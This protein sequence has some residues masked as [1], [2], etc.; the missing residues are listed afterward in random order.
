MYH[1][2]SIGVSNFVELTQE[3]ILAEQRALLGLNDSDDES[4]Y[5]EE[6]EQDKRLP[7]AKPS[8]VNE[9]QHPIATISHDSHGISLKNVNGKPNSPNSVFQ[10]DAINDHQQFMSVKHSDETC[11]VRH[12]IYDF[13][14]DLDNVQ[15]LEAPQIRDN[16]KEQNVGDIKYS[17]LNQPTTMAATN[18]SFVNHTLDHSQD[19]SIVATTTVNSAN[20]SHPH[21]WVAD[22]SVVTVQDVLQAIEGAKQ[23]HLVIDQVMTTVTI[24][25]TMQPSRA[26]PVDH[27]TRA[28][29]P[30]EGEE[31]DLESV[32]EYLDRRVDRTLPR[33]NSQELLSQLHSLMDSS[34]RPLKRPSH[35]E[36]DMNE[37]EEQLQNVKQT[38]NSI[39]N[40]ILESNRNTMIL[41][42]KLKQC[43]EKIKDMEYL[44]KLIKFEH[45]LEDSDDAS[46]GNKED[47]CGD[48]QMKEDYLDQITFSFARLKELETQNILAS[49]KVVELRAT[50]AETQ[51]LVEDLEQERNFSAAKVA[52]LQELLS[53]NSKDEARTH[54]SAKAMQVA[55]LTIEVEQ[56][57]MALQNSDTQLEAL[58]QER[59]ANRT[60]MVGLSDVFRMTD[61][62]LNV[63]NCESAQKLK[64]GEVLTR[65][66]ALELTVVSLRKKVETLAEEKSDSQATI[67]ALKEAMLELQ[68]D[69]EARETKINALESQFLEIN[70]R[71]NKRNEVLDSSVSVNDKVNISVEK[72]S[73][74]A[75]SIETVPRTSTFRIWNMNR[76]KKSQGTNIVK[77]QDVRIESESD[78][79]DSSDLSLTAVAPPPTIEVH[80]GPA[81]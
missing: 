51:A 8:V 78:E 32:E 36:D 31:D 79:D 30:T 66:Q 3:E 68:Q 54:A 37:L 24:P 27:L 34:N 55:T 35:D 61:E 48:G 10:T 40:D 52:E 42:R 1:L 14:L 56:L 75:T 53:I 4:L 67:E 63:E 16:D 39:Q 21:S 18:S 45:D 29:K 74:D 70:R 65:D 19:S 28:Q 5:N 44:G 22:T 23:S 80:E 50:L 64:D 59:D 46:Y 73:T 15:Q 26:Y 72:A 60:M 77:E 33:E 9:K 6:N 13:H 12:L 76:F 2:S 81:Q 41:Q 17:T 62:T 58:Q 71:N 43:K 38:N 47:D 7:L 11:E 20:H 57:R 25:P 49:A 69:N